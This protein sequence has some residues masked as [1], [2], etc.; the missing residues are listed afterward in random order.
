MIRM[1]LLKPS[2]NESV[3]SLEALACVWQCCTYLSISHSKFRSSIQ[4]PEESPVSVEGCHI[5]E[6]LSC[7]KWEQEGA[8]TANILEP[9]GQVAGHD[10]NGVLQL[11]V[12]LGSQ[13][14]VDELSHRKYGSWMKEISWILHTKYER[15][16]YLFLE[17][18]GYS[19]YQYLFKACNTLSRHRTSRLG[20]WKRE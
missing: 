18:L 9:G 2:N 6:E 11:P 13:L 4:E 3:F 10:D 1:L 20:S 17:T 16:T 8:H 7:L 19:V 15:K 12:H 14:G 5:E